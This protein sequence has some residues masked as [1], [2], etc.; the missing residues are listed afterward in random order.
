MA[1][2]GFI[3]RP[4]E[5]IRDLLVVELAGIGG[6][7]G[8]AGGPRSGKSTVMRTL[9]CSLALTHSPREVQFY[10]LDFGGGAL[11]SVAGLP[12]VG[13]VAGRLDADRVTRTVA[14]VTAL[15]AQRERRFAE[16]GVDSMATYRRMR[17]D[18]RVADDPY[19]DVFLV[20]DGWFTLRSEFEALDGP[21]RQIAAQGLNFGVH[22]LLTA[23]RWSEV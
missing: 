13:S 6:H 4:F 1:P 16:L 2:L 12:H 8:I 20:V 3:D 23:G 9:I 10:C 11:S 22:L 14:E 7:V 19:G 15:I 17:A 18:G 21:V 5:Q